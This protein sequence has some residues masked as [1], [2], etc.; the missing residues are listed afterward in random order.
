VLVTEAGAVVVDSMT[1]VRHGEAI[2]KRVRG[3]TPTFEEAS[4]RRSRP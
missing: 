3:L 2:E 4:A 1:F